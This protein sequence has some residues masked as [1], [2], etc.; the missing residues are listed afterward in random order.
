[1]IWS[2]RVGSWGS[3]GLAKGVVAIEIGI[4]ARRCGGWCCGKGS[5]AV[6]AVVCGGWVQWRCRRSRLVVTEEAPSFQARS[7]L[8]ASSNL[9][10]KFHFFL[11]SLSLSNV[12]VSVRKI[13]DQRSCRWGHC[14]FT[15]VSHSQ[16][17]KLLTTS[18]ALDFLS[19]HQ[20]NW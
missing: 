10:S 14:F 5:L 11:C 8:I 3:Q 16:A 15:G 9:S 1:M 12:V 4:G 6:A 2:G 20:R 17:H 18:A 19:M 7:W 13:R